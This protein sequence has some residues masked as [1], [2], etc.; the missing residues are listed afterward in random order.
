MSL[1]IFDGS[2][3]VSIPAFFVQWHKVQRLP[4]T[5][6]VL[7]FQI[8]PISAL[9][10]ACFPSVHGDGAGL[11]GRGGDVQGGL[12][13]KVGVGAVLIKKYTSLPTNPK[14]APRIFFANK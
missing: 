6:I 14:K 7:R 4:V 11:C 10:E 8:A 3:I 12:G 13:I 1:C 2:T 5:F 9:R